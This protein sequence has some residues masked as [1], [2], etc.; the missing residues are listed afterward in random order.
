VQPEAL[1]EM[2]SC[3]VVPPQEVL[4]WSCWSG[5]RPA[6]P[7]QAASL[8]ASPPHSRLDGEDGA[9]SCGPAGEVVRQ[10][11]PAGL[12]AMTCQGVAP[13]PLTSPTGVEG[14][15]VDGLGGCGAA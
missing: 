6:R 4:T 13:S 7:L 11:K 5:L 9:F 3:H 12:R 14:W 10:R 15:L 2:G 1:I 8:A